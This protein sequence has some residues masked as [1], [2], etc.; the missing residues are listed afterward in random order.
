MKVAAT[1]SGTTTLS[2]TKSSSAWPV[3]IIVACFGL[4]WLETINH[5][6]G[7]W[8][9]NP[10]YAYGW[11]VP[12]L[13]LYL[14]WR[15]WPT[16]P[17]PAPSG[18]KLLPIAL[19]ILCALLFLPIR[20]VAEANPDWRL[21]SWAFSVVAVAISIS[22]LFLAG[23]WPWLRHFAFPIVFFLVAVPW[24]THLEQF[25]VQ[26]LM[27]WQTNI[28]VS[29]LNLAGIPAVQSGNVIEV[30]S[31]LIGIEEAC[32]GV[33]SLQATLM[34]SLFLG[35]LYSFNIAGRI[36]LVAAGALFAF[37]CNL[38]RTGIL[39]WVGANK[40]TKAIEAWHDPAG[41]TILLI[42]LAGLWV[43]SL[44]MQRRAVFLHKQQRNDEIGSTVRFA[45]A[46]LVGLVVWILL[47]EI[48]VQSWYRLN[49]P[50]MPDTRWAVNW[51]TAESDYKSV[52]IPK[53]AEHLLLYNE[54][55]AGAWMGTDNRPW[56][57]YFFRWFPGR[58]AA[59]FVKI[60]RPDVCLPA[61]GMTLSHDAGLRLI[62][63]NG[64]SLPI[65]SY[66][67]YDRGMPLHVFYCYSDGRSSYENAS[68]AAEEDWTARGRVRAAWEG[69][70]D[71]GAQ[72]LEVVVWGY[73]DDREAEQA[74]QRQLAKIIELG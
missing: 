71:V 23:G 27:H 29:L 58:T 43:L 3:V 22:Y 2:E 72:M 33:R 24:P 14:F 10:Q 52:P 44:I 38:V 45:P 65:R 30:G 1:E 13:A 67:F 32:S 6:K 35:E 51:P 48:G 74:L 9:Y 59:L 4:L 17:A 62:T 40:G 57:M 50:S 31:S 5:L 53:E 19:V 66:R 39:V 49:R 18:Q 41:M 55:G 26:H 42:C 64:V 36:V 20:F 61:S 60:H 16:R 12:F 54:G 37:F 11:G 73:D 28:N 70:R 68:A 63:V 47:T 8:S 69:K 25:V 7:E 56:M 15:R 34:V 21:L 46:L